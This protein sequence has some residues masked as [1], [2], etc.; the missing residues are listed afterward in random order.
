MATGTTFRVKRNFTAGELSPLMYGRTDNQR[1]ENGA[2]RMYNMYTKPQG[3]S[4]RRPGFRFIYD[5]TTLIGGTVDGKPEPRM[6]PFIVDQDTAYILCFYPHQSGTTRIVFCINDGLLAD[7]VIPTNPL[8]FEITGVFDLEN[9]RYAQSGDIL[10]IT[11]KGRMPLELIRTAPDTWTINEVVLIDTPADWTADN[12]PRLVSFFEQRIGYHANITRPNTTWMS[13][14]GDFYDFSVTAESANLESEAFTFTLDSAQ[15]NRIQWVASA[16]Q[17]MMGTLGDE[18][19]V[20]GAQGQPLSGTTIDVDRQTSHG[21]EDL[22]PLSIGAAVLFLERLGRV[23]D[24]FIFDFNIN[25]WTV[26]DLSILAPHFTELNSIKDWAHQ[27]TPNSIVWCVRD[28]GHLLGMT[29]QRE[30]NVIAWHEHE[31]DGEFMSI[32]TIPGQSRETEVWTTIKRTIGGVDKWYIEKMESEFISQDFEKARFMDS[33][34]VYSGPATGTITGLEHL[35]GK[36]VSVMANG[37]VDPPAVVSGGQIELHGEHTHVVVGLPYLSRL[38]PLL[39]EDEKRDGSTSGRTYR[40]SKLILE[41]WNS[42]GLTLTRKNNDEGENAPITEEIPFRQPSDLTGTPVPPYSGYK[43]IDFPEGSA[44]NMD[45]ILEQNQPLPMTVISV[46]DE[47]KA[48][49]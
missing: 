19:S 18:W 20:D 22:M 4:V 27:H 42:L 21:S 48:T 9:F 13:W 5:L 10:Y 38:S 43:V 32:G 37:A 16:R 45:V 39:N 8:V 3:P 25:G 30:H 11:Q 12:Y 35:E 36:T 2:K 14:S 29:F 49:K 47:Y 1:Y 7:P 46:V 31:T 40:I 23:V 6:V 33:H 15:Q 17:L 26:S 41:F 44:R 28:D 34:L 24:M